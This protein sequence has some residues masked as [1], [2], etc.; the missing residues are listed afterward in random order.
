M[1]RLTPSPTEEVANGAG[2]T[3]DLALAGEAGLRR[4]AFELEL[5]WLQAVAVLETMPVRFVGDASFRRLGFECLC[6]CAWT[7]GVVV[8]VV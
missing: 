8:C 6:V 3:R 7:R 5:G 2:Q 1:L 4:V